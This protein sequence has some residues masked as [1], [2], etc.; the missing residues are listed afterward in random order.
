ME[1]RPLG[2]TGLNVSVIG[3]GAS[4]LGNEFRPVTVTNCDRAVDAAIDQGINFFDVAPYYGRTLAEQRLGNA[5]AGKRESVLLSTKCGRYDRE[6]FDFS[7][8]RT[9]ASLE[10]SLR[11]LRTDYIDLYQ[12]HDV[13]FGSVRQIIEETIPAMRDLQRAGKVRFIG[14]TGYN[15]RVLE[16]IADQAGV[17]TILSYCRY[18]LLSDELERSLRL[19]TESSGTGLINASPLHMGLLTLE[20][21]PAWHPAAPEVIAAGKR[22]VDL[23]V[24]RGVDPSLFALRYCLEYRYASTTVVGMSSEEIVAANCWALKIAF[25]HELLFA[26]RAAIE[27][28]YN[29]PWPSGLPEN[30]DPI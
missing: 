8:G 22:A 7:A 14:I 4:P 10:A 13:E 9:H 21:P 12:V 29:R 3:F 11:R 23:L 16:K 18:N 26:V 1:Y 27:G 30:A 20:G 28:G 5:L 24:Q 2:R 17:D 25:D 19:F 6:E 15:L